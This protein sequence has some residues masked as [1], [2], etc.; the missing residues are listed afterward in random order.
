MR[1]P[2]KD[3]QEALEESLGLARE[4]K[5][6]WLEKLV[7]AAGFGRTDLRRLKAGQVAKLWSVTPQAVGL[8]HSKSGCPRN[9][10]STYDLAQVIRWREEL[11]EEKPAAPPAREDGRSPALEKLRELDV[12][13]KRMDLA[14]RRG[15]LVRSAAVEAQWT[16]AAR[17]LRARCEALAEVV[18]GLVRHPP[19]EIERAVWEALGE[20]VTGFRGDLQ[21]N[22]EEIGC[23]VSAAENG[24]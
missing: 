14:E 17:R 2:P 11:L 15:E 4:G 3:Q 20:L 1:A 23:D 22:A 9:E 6:P 5:L 24:D 21:G 8:W 7:L 10:D 19:A 12:E 18:V 13:G 16:A